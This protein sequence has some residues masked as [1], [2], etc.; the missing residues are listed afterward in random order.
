MSLLASFLAAG[1]LASAPSVQTPG[2][3]EVPVLAGAQRA[4][5]CGNL[6]GLVSNAFCVTTSLSNMEG[7]TDAYVTHFGAQG[8]LIAGGSGDRAVFVRRREGGGC[9]GLQMMAFRDT[10]QPATAEAPGYL[11]FSSVP[12]ACGAPEETKSE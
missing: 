4:P 3:V 11:G 9:E 7:L 5:D 2:G 6:Y 1:V 12:G 8:W 10:S